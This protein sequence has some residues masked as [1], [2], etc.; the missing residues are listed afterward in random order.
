MPLPCSN[1]QK[2]L[3]NTN[4]RNLYNENTYYVRNKVNTSSTWDKTTNTV[5]P[6]LNKGSILDQNR[7]EVHAWNFRNQASFNR[8]LGK[9][10]EINAVAGMEVD[11]LVT[12]KFTNPTSYGYNDKTL[13][14]GTFP[15]GPGGAYAPIKD[16]Q[17]YNETFSYTNV[18]TYT[19]QRYFSLYGN[20][21]Y[22]YL[23]KYTLSGSLRTDA[24]NLITDDPSYRYSPFW[25]LGGSWQLRKEKFMDRVA[26]LDQLTVRFTYGYNGNVDPTTAFRPL[27]STAANPNTYTH[28]YTASIS[29]YGN[30]TLRWEK[31]GSINFGFDYSLLGGKFFGKVDLYSKQGKDLIAQISIPAINGTT[32]QKLNNAEMSNKGIELELGTHIPIRGNDITWQGSVNFSYNKNKITNLFVA[33]YEAYSLT[34]GGTAAYVEGY[35]ANSS[36][37]F[38][39]AGVHD[40]QP[41]IKG[42]GDNMFD[43]TAWTTGDGREFMLNMGTKV[44]PYTLGFINS[45]KIYDFDFSFI[46]TGK[47][48]HVFNR[49]SFNYPVLWGSRL[50]PN[51]KLAEVI[52]GDPASIVPL[53]QNENEPRYYFWDRFYPYLSYLSENASHIRMQEVYL[54]YHLPMKKIKALG[55][56]NVQVFLQGN[57]LFTVLF[58]DA[59]EDPEYPMGTINP[60]P[61]FTLGV[62]VGF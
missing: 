7:T 4:N 18:F 52:N 59:G 60:A 16:W 3:F 39:Y 53:P 14:V 35:D 54:G 50:L 34:D 57:D 13:T 44:A 11:N 31:T 5:T 21:A 43:F 37:M 61:K 48:G 33:K 23:N 19:T 9:D 49:M 41:M 29:S 47:F 2:Q 55:T 45:F 62:K 12:E 36:W 27:I 15:N 58:N 20:A 22:T 26:W 40:G 6:N 38:Q 24:S 8:L 51:S 25:S 30:P 32:S 46:L 28:D 1:I 17:G 10:H 56:S 42:P